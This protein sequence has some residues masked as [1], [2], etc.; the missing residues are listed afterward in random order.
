MTV[1]VIISTH[2]P[3]S[4]CALIPPFAG[5]N[6]GHAPV[7]YHYRESGTV[8]LA[9]KCLWKSDRSLATLIRSDRSARRD[10]PPDTPPSSE[11]QTLNSIAT[12]RSGN[13]TALP[14]RRRKESGI[15]H[16]PT[17]AI[18]SPES[19]SCNNRRLVSGRFHQRIES[20]NDMTKIASKIDDTGFDTMQHG[21]SV[22]VLH[23]LTGDTRHWGRAPA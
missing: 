1:T 12:D 8:N 16:H 6:G 5:D 15:P 17:T 4:R 3:T 23:K 18:P 7:I 20:D 9:E 13:L 10:R 19:R 11:T 21:I 2:R 14:A 22:L